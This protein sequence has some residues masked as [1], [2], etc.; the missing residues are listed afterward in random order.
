VY[1]SDNEVLKNM[2]EKFWEY[3][4]PQKQKEV[5]AEL[6]SHRI[7]S[8]REARKAIRKYL[9][10][11]KMSKD[12]KKLLE[13]KLDYYDRVAGSEKKKIEGLPLSPEEKEARKTELLNQYIHIQL[14]EIGKRY[15]SL[16][17]EEGIKSI[18][19]EL[20]GKGGG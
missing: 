8:N 16:G 13:E 2:K 18:R 10:G 4:D 19:D 11:E 9:L 20:K 6:V 15:K 3:R 5:V 1:S 14:S 17:I 12:E 7:T